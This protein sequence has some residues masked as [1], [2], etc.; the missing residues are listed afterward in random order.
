MRI[1]KNIFYNIEESTIFYKF[2]GLI[3]YFSSDFNLDRFTRGLQTYI[4]TNNMKLSARYGI[5]IELDR[6]FAINYY[7]QIEKRGRKILKQDTKEELNL[8][9]IKFYDILYVGGD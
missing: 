6:F 8:S 1:S 4:N 2:D 5:N 3:F 7:K 9:K